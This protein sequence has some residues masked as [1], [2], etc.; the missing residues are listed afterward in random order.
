GGKQGLFRLR[1]KVWEEMKDPAGGAIYCTS[2]LLDEDGDLW[3]GTQDKGLMLFRDNQWSEMA[4]RSGPE[5]GEIYHLQQDR[6]GSIWLSTEL[7]LYR[8]VGKEYLHWGEEEGLPSAW[9]WSVLA[10][11]DTSVW[12]GHRYGLGRLTPQGFEQYGP[13]D[14]FLAGHPSQFAR[15]EYGAL[16]LA[17][18]GGVVRYADGEFTSI[19]VSEDFHNNRTFLALAPGNGKVYVAGNKSIEW[20]DAN[21]VGGFERHKIQDRLTISPNG[22]NYLYLDDN[23]KLWVATEGKGL[24]SITPSGKLEYFNNLNGLPSDI[25]NAM[26]TD[27]QGRLWLAT[28]NGVCVVDISQDTPTIV[29]QYST[30]DGLLSFNVYS[31]AW[32]E[33]DLWL[34]T[35]QGLNRLTFQGDSLVELAQFTG[36]QGFKG[37]EANHKAVSVSAEGNIWWGTID[38][39]TQYQ[40]AYDDRVEENPEIYVTNIDLFYDDTEWE[41]LQKAPLGW[42]GLPATLSLSPT[43]NTLTF[44][45]RAVDLQRGKLIRYQ[46]RLL[47]LEEDWSPF[48]QQSQVR[49]TNLSPGEYT[50]EVR[51]TIGPHV[52]ASV[53][54]YSFSISPYLWQRPWFIILVSLSLIG[55]IG[56]YTQWRLTSLRKTRRILTEKVAE[57]TRE[58]E[59]QKAEIEDQRDQIENQRDELVDQS[60]FLE[61]A[62]QDLKRNNLHMRSSIEYAKRI[63]EAIL[64]RPAAIRQAY[65]DNF[66]LLQ[67]KDI[68]SGDFYWYGFT[69]HAH[70]VVVADCTGHG[71]PGAI[72]SMIGHALLNQIILEKQIT[73]PATILKMM[74][75]GIRLAL[76]QDDDEELNHDGMDMAVLAV[77]KQDNF[78]LYAGAKR[79]LYLVRQEKLIAYPG[80][81]FSIGGFQMNRALP[82]RNHTVPLETGD[83]VYLTTDG[84]ADQFGGRTERKFMLKRFKRLLTEIS[85]LPAGE[86]KVILKDMQS[87]WRQGVEQTDDMLIIGLRID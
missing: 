78:G 87:V 33:N 69:N 16:W 63:Q 48:T 35:D 39:L 77:S 21:P 62:L 28:G 40:A 56:L 44:S 84:Y 51:A 60:K 30:L 53:S 8:L 6:T 49:Y 11:S 4:S 76:N 29:G 59:S 23:D 54:Q 22:F 81:R 26:A 31:I 74:H 34:G 68:V 55:I 7:G 58:I 10:E 19:P 20:I 70:I 43:Q 25:V 61:Q 13:E 9:I 41:A 38:A 64:P 15:D 52:E 36:D 85:G 46:S 82:F 32:R 45:Y 65:P 50:F 37:I 1:D 86:Q 42:F 73:D 72:M 57:R 12:V 2:L 79:P 14:G 66:I 67:P 3:V 47:G 75:A 80:D 27:E 5:E 18:Q 24:A 71:V 83:M 17:C